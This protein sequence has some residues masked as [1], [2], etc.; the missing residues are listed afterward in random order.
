MKIVVFK[1][2]EKEYGVDIIQIKEVVRMRA[3]TPV[4]ESA[5]FVEGVISL[6]GRV[7][8][9]LSLRKKLDMEQPKFSVTNRI[10]V[11]ESSSQ[12]VGVIVDSVSDVITVEEGSLTPPDDVLKEAKYL[13]G[14][15]KVEK[16]LILFADMHKLLSVKDKTSIK[17]VSQRVEVHRKSQV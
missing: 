7:V 14:V 10:I 4:P 16:R 11:T 13:L 17:K 8:P 15:I 6:R 1:I 3:I 12:V 2:A 9:V 5:D